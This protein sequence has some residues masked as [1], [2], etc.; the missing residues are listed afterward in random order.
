MI[1][2]ITPCALA[3]EL[4]D[5][6]PKTAQKAKASVLNFIQ[7]LPKIMVRID[8]DLRQILAWTFM[9]RYQLLSLA[10]FLWIFKRSFVLR[11]LI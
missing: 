9:E 8:H 1:G 6:A 10:R 5:R 3:D 7:I 2:T 11:H 4:N